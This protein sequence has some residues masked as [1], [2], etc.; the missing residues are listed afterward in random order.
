MHQ[1]L[2]TCTP[3]GSSSSMP[4]ALPSHPAPTHITLSLS[5]HFFQTPLTLPCSL[6]RF[7]TLPMRPQLPGFY[8]VGFPVGVY[9]LCTARV[10]H[11]HSSNPALCSSCMASNS[12]APFQPATSRACMALRMYC[13]PAEVRYNRPGGVP[14]APPGACVP[15][16]PALPRGALQGDPLL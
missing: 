7:L 1:S 12:R 13:L 6:T 2:H 3:H 5:H 4:P 9:R 10:L 11:V 14:E 15:R 16:G 8:I